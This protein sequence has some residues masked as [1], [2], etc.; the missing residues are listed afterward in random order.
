MSSSLENRVEAILYLKAKPLTIKEISEYARANLEEVQ[1]A[2]IPLMDR[3]AHQD[4]ALEVLETP[5]GFVLQLRSEFQDL[6]HSLIPVDLGVGALRTL[7]VIALK[8]SVS[9]TELVELRGS[10]AYQQVQ[11]LV[12]QGFVGKRRQKDS[13][14]YRL[15]VTEKFHQY[16]QIEGPGLEQR[17]KQLTVPL[18]LDAQEEETI[19]ELEEDMD[20]KDMD[21]EDHEGAL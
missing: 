5:K 14:S 3:Y 17:L 21:E 15:Q 8:G 10:G 12:E 19:D 16:F 6:V 13:R 1:D 4:S 11:N 20:E 9:Q 7:A 18:V 2:L